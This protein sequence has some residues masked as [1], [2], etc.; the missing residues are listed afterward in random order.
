MTY[1][2]VFICRNT[3][4]RQFDDLSVLSATK[5]P[6]WKEGNNGQKIST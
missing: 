4:D 2:Y 3:Q 5:S 6:T 1:T